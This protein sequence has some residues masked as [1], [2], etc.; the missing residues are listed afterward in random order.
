MVRIEALFLALLVS[1]PAL[2][3]A[4]ILDERTVENAL[5]RYVVAAVVCTIAVNLLCNMYLQFASGVTSRRLQE[6]A[7]Q[8]AGLAG[9]DGAATVTAT[10]VD[11]PAAREGGHDAGAVPQRR[12]SDRG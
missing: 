4:F 7:A 9:A 6:R 5:I 8:H 10:L 1:A 2:Y 12:A 3:E 11:V